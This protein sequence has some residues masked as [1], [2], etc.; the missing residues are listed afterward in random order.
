MYSDTVS[1]GQRVNYSLGRDSYCVLQKGCKFQKVVKHRMRAL[2]R[3]FL[4][5]QCCLVSEDPL[6]MIY[7]MVFTSNFLNLAS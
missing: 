1:Q 5:M 6:G 4:A 2:F 7:V 3:L